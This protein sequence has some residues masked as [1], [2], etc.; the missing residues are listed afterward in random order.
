MNFTTAFSIICLISYV[1]AHENES[2][3]IECKS[4][5]TC[6]NLSR[7][8]RSI[9]LN[10]SCDFS[11]GDWRNFSA[12]FPKLERMK[13]FPECKNCL[14]IDESFPKIKVE[15]RCL[16]NDPTC[17]HKEDLKTISNE[18]ISCF[19][20]LLTLTVLYIIRFIKNEI[21]QYYQQCQNSMTV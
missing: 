11:V 18:I 17:K 4:F 20:L 21:L 2:V 12:C 19:I 13:F 16:E 8:L 9:F 5:N 7:N 14:K 10:N 3:I 1:H 15:G 6:R